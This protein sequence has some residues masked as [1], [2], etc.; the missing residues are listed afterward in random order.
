[1]E[2]LNFTQIKKRMDMDIT[3][4]NK[5]CKKVAIEYANSSYLFTRSYFCKTYNITES[6]FYKVLRRAVEEDLV[7]DE[8]VQRM[9]NK[10]IGKQQKYAKGAGSNTVMKYADMKAKRHIVQATNYAIE[11]ANNPDISK[12]QIA[13]K[14][15]VTVKKLD[16]LLAKAIFE[17]HVDDSVVDAIEERSIRNAKQGQEELTRSFFEGLRKKRESYKKWMQSK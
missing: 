8:T 3:E 5:F 16:Q 1:M 11:F 9:M 10:A 6:C 4:I 17:N 7:D 12:K 13:E 14:H 15:G 2:N